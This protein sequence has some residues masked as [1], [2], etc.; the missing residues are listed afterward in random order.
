MAESFFNESISRIMQSMQILVSSAK[1]AVNI[2]PDKL[3]ATEISQLQLEFD[4][5][6]NSAIIKL[7]SVADEFSR[8]KCINEGKS[9]LTLATSVLGGRTYLED[10]MEAIKIVGEK[11]GQMAVNALSP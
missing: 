3:T 10:Y 6:M 11:H 4:S 2:D 7:C 5:A 9:F 1:E 8:C